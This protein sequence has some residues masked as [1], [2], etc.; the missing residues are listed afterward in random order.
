MCLQHRSLCFISKY[1][2]PTTTSC[3]LVTC[4]FIAVSS[5]FPFHIFTPSMILFY[6]QYKARRAHVKVIDFMVL[7]SCA[8]TV[9]VSSTHLKTL[10]ARMVMWSK[11][12][13]EDQ[14]ISRDTV[15]KFVVGVNWR[16]ESVHPWAYLTCIHLVCK[17]HLIFSCSY[18]RY[19][20]RPLLHRVYSPAKEGKRNYCNCNPLNVIRS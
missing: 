15:R 10:E 20:V 18:R 9:Q 19:I 16:P 17:A 13:T 5:Y 11:F 14:Q 4:L 7:S 12:H 1:L 3:R 2:T 8:Q 6:R